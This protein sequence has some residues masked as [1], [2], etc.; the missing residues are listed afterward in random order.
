VGL[1]RVARDSDR[2]ALSG[3]VRESRLQ[4]ARL[5]QKTQDGVRSRFMPPRNSLL[6]TSDC[7]LD[8]D[9]EE[10]STLKDALKGLV[11]PA[12]EVPNAFKEEA[13]TARSSGREAEL[14]DAATEFARKSEPHPRPLPPCR[15]GF[16]IVRRTRNRVAVLRLSLSTQPLT[17]RASQNPTFAL[18]PPCPAG[19]ETVRETR[20]RRWKRRPRPLAVLR[21]SLPR[22]A[23]NSRRTL[24]LWQTC[25]PGFKSLRGTRSR[26]SEQ[27]RRLFWR[28]ACPTS[29]PLP[30]VISIES[31]YGMPRPWPRS[32]VPQR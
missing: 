3:A 11:R 14:A 16:K 30:K 21:R 31:G 2:S 6:S 13:V 17:S 23:Q 18:Y 8:K 32:L 4:D 5:L 9:A 27:K 19:F 29:L 20:N 26:R 10:L 24:A 25:R 12:E 28:E 7:A 1:I 15:A 22:R